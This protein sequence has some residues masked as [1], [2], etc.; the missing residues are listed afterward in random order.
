MGVGPASAVD[1]KAS[2]KRS[3]GDPDPF[4]SFKQFVKSE[5]NWHD[6]SIIPARKNGTRPIGRQKIAMIG[7]KSRGVLAA[8]PE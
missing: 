1:N 5:P 8:E 3:I 7:Y 6:M 4:K 2:T